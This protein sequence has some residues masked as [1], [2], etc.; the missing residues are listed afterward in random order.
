MPEDPAPRTTLLTT[1]LADV[2]VPAA[3]GGIVTPEIE[4]SNSVGDPKCGFE[5][6]LLKSETWLSMV[7]STPVG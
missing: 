5:I 1:P 2:V 7:N 6:L 4:K 3:E